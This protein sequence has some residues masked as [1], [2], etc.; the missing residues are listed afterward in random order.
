MRTI[1]RA[2]N[3]VVVP[4]FSIAIAVGLGLLAVGYA[5]WRRARAREAVAE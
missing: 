4:W 1:E 3:F 5:W 2:E